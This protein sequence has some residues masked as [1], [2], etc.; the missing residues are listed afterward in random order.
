MSRCAL[1]LRPFPW[2]DQTRRLKLRDYTDLSNDV[3]DIYSFLDVI[4]PL[5]DVRFNL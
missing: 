4:S 3:A 2:L 5:A 1:Q